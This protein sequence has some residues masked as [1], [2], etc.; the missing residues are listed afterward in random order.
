MSRPRVADGG[1]GLQIRRVTAKVLNGQSRTAD[2]GWSSCFGRGITSHRK[3]K[4]LLRN[5][6]EGLGIA[7]DSRENDNEP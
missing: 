4:C 2:K 1:Y 3:K 7:A 6:T 5:V